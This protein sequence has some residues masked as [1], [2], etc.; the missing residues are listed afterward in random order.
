MTYF[1][2]GSSSAEKKKKKERKYIIE[3]NEEILK[4]LKF[5]EINVILKQFQN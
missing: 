2:S 1:S 5:G 4:N 3:V